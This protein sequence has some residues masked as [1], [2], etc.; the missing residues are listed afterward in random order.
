MRPIK[1]LKNASGAYLKSVDRLRPVPMSQHRKINKENTDDKNEAK[2]QKRDGQV[3]PLPTP[4][5]GGRRNKKKRFVGERKGYVQH[6]LKQKE[7]YSRC[8]F[9]YRG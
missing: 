1:D 3:H 4:E 7:S 6:L 9:W 2:I 8:I 5:E